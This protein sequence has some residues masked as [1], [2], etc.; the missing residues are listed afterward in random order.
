MIARVALCRHHSY[1]LQSLGLILFSAYIIRVIFFLHSNVCS[2]IYSCCASSNSVEPIFILWNFENKKK[3][4]LKFAQS[5]VSSLAIVSTC[6]NVT[7]PHLRMMTFTE[8]FWLHY[9]IS[10]NF[11][12]VTKAIICCCGKKIRDFQLCSFLYR[13]LC[14]GIWF[15]YKFI[16]PDED[17]FPGEL[18]KWTMKDMNWKITP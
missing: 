6:W 11:S 8:K 15:V 2:Y 10:N 4:G 3:I 13:G 7:L 12:E 17:E 16:E 1:N 9:I 14:L 18:N 5:R